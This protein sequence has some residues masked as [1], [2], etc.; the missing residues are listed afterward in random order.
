MI[1]LRDGNLFNCPHN[2]SMAHCISADAKMSK[3]IALQFVDNFPTLV[4]LRNKENRIGTAIA[5]CVGTRIVYSLVTKPRFWMKPSVNTLERCLKSMLDHAIAHGIKDICVPKLASGCD[6]LNF[7][8]AVMP[9][10]EK[11]FGDQPVNLHV[12]LNRYCIFIV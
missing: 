5:I 3:G 2:Y 10:L 7:D 9:V 6:K 4:S 12:Y 1:I 8:D 11:V